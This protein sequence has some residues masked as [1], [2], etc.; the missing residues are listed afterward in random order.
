MK[1]FR[2]VSIALVAVFAF[3][4]AMAADIK[5]PEYQTVALDNG[6]TCC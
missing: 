5:L 4:G 2:S 6:A 3:N 1:F